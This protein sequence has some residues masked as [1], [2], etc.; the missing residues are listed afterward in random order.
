MQVLL[1][2]FSTSPVSTSKY[3]G[4]S[5]KKGLES[6]HFSPS[7][8]TT[9]AQATSPFHLA[10]LDHDTSLL[11]ASTL[12]SLYSTQSSLS[13]HQSPLQPGL[14]PTGLP[15]VP[16]TYRHF[17]PQGLCTRSACYLEYFPTRYPP[18]GSLTSNSSLSSVSS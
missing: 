3:C 8:G 2:G 15:M 12:S 10:A 9:V 18:G 6:I 16:Q 13:S 11:P 14:L 4:S 1:E 5:F 7:T 17:L